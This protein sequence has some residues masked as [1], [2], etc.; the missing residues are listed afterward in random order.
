MIDRFSIIAS[1]AGFLILDE[2]II[3][4][5]SEFSDQSVRDSSLSLTGK[6]PED[7]DICFLC[8]DLPFE[9]LKTHSNKASRGRSQLIPDAYRIVDVDHRACKDVDS[10]EYYSDVINCYLIKSSAVSCL[11][12]STPICAPMLR[13]F[14]QLFRDSKLIGYILEDPLFKSHNSVMEK[15]KHFAKEKGNAA[16]GARY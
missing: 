8:Q 5:K 11:L 7:C 9:Y 13:Y 6:L 12:E 14:G 15:K 3:P 16:R 10:D 1:M 4:S 2:N